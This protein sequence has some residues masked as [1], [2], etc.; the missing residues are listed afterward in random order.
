MGFRRAIIPAGANAGGL[1]SS[2]AAP[3][4]GRALSAVPD[5][6]TGSLEVREVESVRQAVAAA[7]SD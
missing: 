5:N 7:L 1:P 4:P 6:L 2:S 3:G